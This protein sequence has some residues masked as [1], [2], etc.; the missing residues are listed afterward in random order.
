MMRKVL[1]T[2][3]FMIFGLTVKVIAQNTPKCP[4]VSVTGSGGIVEPGQEISFVLNIKNVDPKLKLTYKW[5]SNGEIKEG[6]GTTLIKVLF[7]EPGSNLISTV[8][9]FGLPDGCG[10]VA[11]EAVIFC[12]PPAAELIFEFSGPLTSDSLTWI[13][14][15]Y[16]NRNP[17]NQFYVMLPGNNNSHSDETRDTLSVLS[18]VF[19]E[20]GTFEFTGKADSPIKIYAVPPGAS[21]PKP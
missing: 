11:T 13:Q 7:N 20:R 5:T 4:E 18:S 10:S 15:A 19:Q 17:T 12:S 16:K 8:E 3:L 1:I 6:Q 21:N 2:L 9:I 14:E